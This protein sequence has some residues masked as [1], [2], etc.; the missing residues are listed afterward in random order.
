M[1]SNRFSIFSL[2]LIFLLT[3]A[4]LAVSLSSNAE[5]ELIHSDWKMEDPLADKPPVS[6]V[7][8]QTREAKIKALQTKKE[9]QEKEIEQK[10]EDISAKRK[11]LIECMNQKGVIL[12][13][14]EECEGCKTQKAYF[15]DDFKDVKYV[16]CNKN[17]FTCPFRGIKSHPTWYLG[18]QLG[19]KKEG[20]K[21]LPTLGKL[22]GCGF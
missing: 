18:S 10:K 8:L 5:F 7:E 22:T 16:D 1:K 13:S 6:A 17:K 9:E 15:G 2:C 12:F 4:I 3:S 20:V 14:I 19:I 11:K 21:D